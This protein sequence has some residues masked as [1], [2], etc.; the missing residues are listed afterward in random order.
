MVRDAIK[1][2][3]VVGEPVIVIAR[4]IA[5]AKAAPVGRDQ[6]TALQ[7]F[8]DELPAGADIQKAVTEDD[9]NAAVLLTPMPQMQLEAADGDV[10][11]AAQRGFRAQASSPSM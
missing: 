1:V 7:M 11:A 9:R 10:F 6:V 8:R 2:G 5:E 4:P 3:H